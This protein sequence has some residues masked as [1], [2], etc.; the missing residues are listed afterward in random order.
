VNAFGFSSDDTLNLI[1]NFKRD[2]FD[3]LRLEHQDL[4]YS[5]D[6]R[7]S[8]FPE[9]DSFKRQRLS[10][11]SRLTV[12]DRSIMSAA[13]AKSVSHPGAKSAQ[14]QVH[15]LASQGPPTT[16]SSA[17]SGPNDR[18]VKS[19]EMRDRGKF[20]RYDQKQSGAPPAHSVS[21]NSHFSVDSITSIQPSLSITLY[22][23]GF[24]ID[25]RPN[26]HL[27]ESAHI[28]LLRSIG[29]GKLP[30][31][32][33]LDVSNTEHLQFHNGSLLAEIKDHRMPIGKLPQNSSHIATTRRVLLQADHLNTIAD[34]EHMRRVCGSELSV[35]DALKVEQDIMM[36]L[37]VPVCLDSSPN[38]SLVC[39]YSQFIRNAAR[40]CLPRPPLSSYRYQ[41]VPSDEEQRAVLSTCKF[42]LDKSDSSKRT[43]K[44]APR[45]SATEGA[46]VP[47]SS[48]ASKGGPKMN[49]S[50]F[51][52]APVLPLHSCTKPAIR[53]MRFIRKAS[54]VGR[55]MTATI[56]VE[57]RRPSVYEGVVRVEE[58]NVTAHGIRDVQRPTCAQYQIGNALQV[59]FSCLQ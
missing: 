5:A 10:T 58:Y 54:G 29:A 24:S 26:A 6:K 3:T 15:S 44:K 13:I 1:H 53:R 9:D 57:L 27:Y 11:Q 46:D 35:S 18:D 21:I 37:Q 36:R 20:D 49:A 31:S 17:F 12:L 45:S 25:G 41:R 32:C 47:D 16:S 50:M 59:C 42:E 14:G 7:V 28:P 19:S 52:P 34:V 2:S 22:P 40:G 48:E 51:A 23:G 55:E 39:N 4:L 33:L 43:P 8:I 56:W 38:L 30:V